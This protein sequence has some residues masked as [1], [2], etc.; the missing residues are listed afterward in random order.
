MPAAIDVTPVKWDKI[1]V[2]FDDGGYSVICGTYYDD[3]RRGQR[4]KRCIGTR[5]NGE[6]GKKG[7]PLASGYSVWHVEP[8]FLTLP[9]LHALLSKAHKASSQTQYIPAIEEAIGEFSRV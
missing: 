7:F 4:V 9:I 1:S 8:D 5:W 2:L 6:A 3:G